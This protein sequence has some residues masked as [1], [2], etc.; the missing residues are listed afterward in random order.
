MVIKDPIQLAN[1]YLSVIDRYNVTIVDF[2]IEGA[3]IAETASVDIRNQALKVVKEKKPSVVLS[4]T[5]PT[6]PNGL[7]QNGV[8]L[9]KSAVKFA[10][11]IQI[12]NI[13]AMDY[14][15]GVAPNGATGMG[16]YAI[17]AAKAV[18]AQAQ[19][20]G[21][22][23]FEIAVT[24]MVSRLPD[25][26]YCFVLTIQILK[27]GVNDVAGEV[28][29]LEDA[30]QLVEFGKQTAWLGMLSYWSINRDISA[31]GPLYKSSQIT[32]KDFEFSG[33]F[34]D[35]EQTGS[36]PSVTT[37][38]AAPTPSASSSPEGNISIVRYDLTFNHFE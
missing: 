30:R 16:G 28:F 29:R 15:A 27:I 24:P 6:L 20:A 33:I 36:S 26:I 2:D 22:K 23:N 21:M 35:F 18:Y 31:F 9:L 3:A 13:M 5:L 32:Q 1:A 38:Q 11:P 25:M 8:D 34:K 14:G 17:S 12:V 4:Y 10:A 37:T 7:T 19:A